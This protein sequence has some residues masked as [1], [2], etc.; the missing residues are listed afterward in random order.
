MLDHPRHPGKKGEKDPNVKF[1]Q[2]QD[3]H[4]LSMELF[5]SLLHNKIQA[6]AA[7]TLKVRDA[8]MAG[9]PGV[10]YL[11]QASEPKL[12]NLSSSNSSTTAISNHI[13]N[14]S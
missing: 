4:V 1:R 14:A 6:T 8:T 7:D 5:V 9:W 10:G 13:P 2:M 3:N 11:D 12:C